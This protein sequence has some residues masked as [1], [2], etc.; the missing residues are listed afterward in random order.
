LLFEGRYLHCLL[1]SSSLTTPATVSNQTS[2]KAFLL[3]LASILAATVALPKLLFRR[4]D[5]G[6]AEATG[7]KPS[8][9]FSLKSDPRAVAR[10]G[11]GRPA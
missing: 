4:R 2:R 1:S 8:S 7:E 3:G 10:D 5:P 11:S 6:P 9:S